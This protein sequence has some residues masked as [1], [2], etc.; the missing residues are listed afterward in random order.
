VDTTLAPATKLALRD[1]TQILVRPVHPQD[2]DRLREGFARLSAQ[3]RHRRFLTPLQQL[4]DRQV[5]YLTEIDYA[6]HMAWVALDPSQPGEPGVGVARYVRLPDEETVAEAAVTVLDEYQGRGIGT[7]LLRLL[8]GSALEHGIRSF[9][10]YVLADNDPMVDILD[11]LGAS[12]TREGP[13]LRV[14]VPIPASPDELPDTPTGRVFK[15][16]AKRELPLFGLRYPGVP[17]D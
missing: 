17:D 1:G 7:L 9:R 2:K 4:S 5:R 3:S 13:L 14:D 11:D 10:G 15:S 12:V 16:I 8:A 6:D